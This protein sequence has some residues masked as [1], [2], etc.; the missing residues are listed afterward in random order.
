[1]EIALQSKAHPFDAHAVV[2]QAIEDSL[3]YTVGV[4]GAGFDSFHLGS[5]GLATGTTG[6]VFSDLD[7]EH[8]NLAR[9]EIA[10]A[11]GVNILAASLLA[12]LRASKSLRGAKDAFHAYAR[13]HGIHAC[14]PPGLD[15]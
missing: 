3:A 2:E 9:S 1:M 8:N 13:L 6:A 14:V 11:T 15:T 5:E 10:N 12:A 4:L 7:F